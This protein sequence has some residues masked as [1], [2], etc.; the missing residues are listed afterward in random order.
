MSVP[1][2]QQALSKIVE[3]GTTEEQFKQLSTKSELF[4]GVVVNWDS[5]ESGSNLDT[6]VAALAS[7]ALRIDSEEENDEEDEES[8]VVESDFL[9]KSQQELPK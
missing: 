2:N 6:K 5:E 3:S 9:T 4:W 7:A 8:G 1:A